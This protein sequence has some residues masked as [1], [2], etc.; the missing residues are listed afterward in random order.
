MADCMS[1]IFSLLGQLF[2]FVLPWGITFGAVI[3]G[4]F[5]VPLL[6]KAYKKFF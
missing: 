4:V 5:G 1:V 6:V 3:V 2:N